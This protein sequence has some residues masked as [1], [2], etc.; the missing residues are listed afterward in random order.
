MHLSKIV[1][2][3]LTLAPTAVNAGMVVERLAPGVYA[4]L[5]PHAER[6]DDANSL[7][8]ITA[9]GVVVVDAQAKHERLEQ[10]IAAVQE[11]S[12]QPVTA[13]INTHW[14]GDHTQGNAAYRRA[15]GAAVE[16]IG[17]ESLLE[18]I[19]Q[20]A[21]TD[22]RERVA[23]YEALI[24]EAESQLAKGLSRAGE[25]LTDEQQVK[26]REAIDDAKLWL[27]R[28]RDTRFLVP[29]RSYREE[30]QL[31][32]GGVALQLK[33]CDAHTRGDTVVWL[34]E[35]RILATGDLL[36]DLPYAGHGNPRS[37]V[38]CL[39]ELEKL[40]AAVYVPGHGPVFR[41]HSQLRRVRA[42]IASLV[43]HVAAARDAGMTAGQAVASYQS[44]V[45]RDALAGDDEA[46]QR[47]FDATLAE[48]ITQA[49]KT[50]AP[51]SETLAD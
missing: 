6:F 36:D 14:H 51:Q 11:L 23:N 26:Q 17:H 4:V 34:P 46:A 9:E 25:P 33:H 24:P 39:D 2:I 20:R 18:D 31:D 45:H 44:E 32:V 42:F 47:F 29:D 19:P 16:V 43:T 8:V 30:L 3:T 1:L 10:T 12:D 27:Q 13:V 15:Y 7:V 37:W 41:D 40:D 50:T 5:Q 21:A 35:Q 22:L 38:A 49:W 48:A 28:N